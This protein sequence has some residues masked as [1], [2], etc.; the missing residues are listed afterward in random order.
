MK[1]N[2]KFLILGIVVILLGLVGWKIISGRIVTDPRRNIS[3]VKVDAPGKQTVHYQLQFNG[4]VIPVQ[5]AN[6]FSRVTGNLDRVYVNIGDYVSENQILALIDTTELALQ[7]Q[8][9]GASYVNAKLTYERN[10]ELEKENLVAKQD[11]D[12]AEA[13]MKVAKANYETAETHLEYAHITAPFSGF[14]TKRY[15]DPGVNLVAN[16][17]TLFTL[18][19]LEEMKI[20]INVLEKDIPQIA[21]GKS[22]DIEVDAYPGRKFEGKITRISEAVDLSTRTMAVEV[23]IQNRE[24]LLKPGMF[25]SA[26]IV[27]SDHPNAIT[28]PTY[29]LQKDDKG[30]FVYTVGDSLK[31]HRI[32]VTIGI[33]QNNKTEILTGLTGNERLITTGQQFVR[34]GGQVT[35]Q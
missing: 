32:T 19:S 23:D 35:I 15:L 18:M 3:L 16:N 9:T 4:D 30:Y 31:A 12:N 27:I 13:A 21:T 1:K 33:E 2:T 26:T 14:I 10:V 24:H 22:V 28:V 6:V 25:A 5:Q 7:V 8:Q 20:I 17:S 11:V 34:D 29:A